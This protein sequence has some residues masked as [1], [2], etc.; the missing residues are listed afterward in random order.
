MTA[1]IC[2]L[3]A[4][5]SLDVNRKG[6][7]GL[8]ALPRLRMK[9]QPLA[10]ATGFHTSHLTLQRSVPLTPHTSLGLR[11]DIPLQVSGDWV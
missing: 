2:E 8:Y 9:H 11:P 7:S 6:Y 10:I 1:W 5:Y 3:E 4:L